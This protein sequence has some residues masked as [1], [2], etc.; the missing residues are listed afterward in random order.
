MS[1]TAAPPN[2][3]TLLQPDV[4]T[5]SAF[6]DAI[7][8]YRHEAA[9][10]VRAPKTKKKGP[11]RFFGTVSG[12]FNDRAAFIAAI[13]GITGE[14]VEALYLTLNPDRAGHPAGCQG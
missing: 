6:W 13:Q 2:S 12:Y 8:Q 9:W 14:D 4:A 11:R 10:E 1:R 7:A 5:I 3:V